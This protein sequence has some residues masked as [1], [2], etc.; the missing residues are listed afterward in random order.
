MA[1][2]KVKLGDIFSESKVRSES[3]CTSKRIR[4]RLN[5]A[6][7]ERRPVG[8]EKKGA[9]AYYI[10]KA[11]Q[12]IYGKQN[13]HKGAFGV[14]PPELDGFESS[15]D[16]PS[17]DVRNDCLPEWIFYYFKQG[18]RY[19]GLNR[20]ARGVG[21]KR[22]HP[23]QLANI[24]IPLPSLDEQESLIKKAKKFEGKTNTLIIEIDRQKKLLSKLRQAILQ[25]AIQGKL[26]EDWRKEN[27]DVEPAGELFKRIAAEK[28][29]LVKAKK[30]RK[31]KPLPPVTDDEIPFDIPETW[32][33]CRLGDLSDVKVGATPP[34]YNR[35]FWGGSVHW[36]SSGE[37]A[38]NYITTTKE[39]ITP[40]ALDKTSAELNPKGSILVA[41]IGQGKTRG[42]TAIL[43]I[44]AA[45]NQNVAAIRNFCISSE[46]IWLFFLS[47]YEKTRSGASG[48]SQPALNGIKIKNTEFPLPPLAEQR[49][50][51]NRVE[52]KLALCDKLE[53]EITAAEHH[54]KN[55]SAAI[56][57]EVF[58]QQE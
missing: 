28:A 2:R 37:V 20:L 58:D 29:E 15:A 1:W 34:R 45:T 41:M 47:R 52:A 43:N 55:L 12:F 24:E 4:V 53:A 27:P 51:V 21:S 22:I 18:N 40:L 57:K 50:I 13:F 49:E 42:Q 16:I 54:A 6:G 31:Q 7:V 25:E 38:N 23:K 30:I 14:V 26:T 39:T 48:G 5:I 3:P 33:W 32:E 17:F 8:P 35:L 10:R 11:G 9:T 19:L 36:V 56:L 46:Y 44:D